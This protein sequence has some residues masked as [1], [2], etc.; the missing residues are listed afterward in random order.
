VLGYQEVI[1]SH[2]R[3]ITFNC[4]PDQQFAGGE[5][6]D[7]I[8]RYDSSSTTVKTAVT[9]TGTSITFRTTNILDLWSTTGTPYDVVIAGQRSR[10]TNMGAASLVSGAYEQT[11]TVVRGIDG[12]R[13]TIAAEEPIHVATP[14]RYSL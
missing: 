1:G 6:D 12:I 7:G 8:V 11:A 3:T 14:G 5:Y 4:A 2:S 10:V 13:K 9:L